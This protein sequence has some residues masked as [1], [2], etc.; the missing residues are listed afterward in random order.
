M[1]RS[2]RTQSRSPSPAGES[3]HDIDAGG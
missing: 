2:G 3:T 1:E